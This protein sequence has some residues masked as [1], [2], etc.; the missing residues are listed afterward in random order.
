[1]CTRTEEAET[2]VEKEAEKVEGKQ[3]KVLML[4]HGFCS[5]FKFFSESFPWIIV[6][7]LLCLRASCVPICLKALSLTQIYARKQQIKVCLK[8]ILFRT[9]TQFFTSFE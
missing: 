7:Y 2:K 6:D 1:M 3:N 5:T 9:N 8:I 4:T